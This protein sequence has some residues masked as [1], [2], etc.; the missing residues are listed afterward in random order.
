MT[1]F[2]LNARHFTLLRCRLLVATFIFLTPLAL[3][4]ALIFTRYRPGASPRGEILI[5][6]RLLEL[7]IGLDAS[8]VN[9]GDVW[10]R[11]MSSE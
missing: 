1:S 3:S 11:M 9:S 7:A 10:S 4:R 5:R 2:R 6:F 8:C